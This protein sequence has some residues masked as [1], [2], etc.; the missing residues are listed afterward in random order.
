MGRIDQGWD[1]YDG[2]LPGDRLNTPHGPGGF[3][4]YDHWEAMWSDG[5]RWMPGIVV[6]L[7]DNRKVSFAGPPTEGRSDQG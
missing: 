6:R 2:Y 7:D 5:H 3:V 4:A 1:W